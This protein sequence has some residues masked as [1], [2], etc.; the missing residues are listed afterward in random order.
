MNYSFVIR[1][2][3][4]DDIQSVKE[5][6]DDSFALYKSRIIPEGGL[7]ALN[8]SEE[9]IRQDILTKEVFI[10]FIDQIPVGSIRVNVR[11]DQ[12]AQISRFGV[13]QAYHNIGI[14]KALMN[15]VDKYLQSLDVQTAEL[16]TASR[17]GDLMRFYY[18]RGF[19]VHSTTTDKGYIRALMRKDYK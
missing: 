4:T 19:Y 6:M 3:D 5:V 13:K 8:E 11:S 9:D 10:A 12:I 16:Y 14:G 7:D 18:G 15:L 17:Y 1:K 2:A